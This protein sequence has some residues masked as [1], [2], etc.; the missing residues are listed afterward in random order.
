MVTVKNENMI[1]GAT[2]QD[3]ATPTFDS[4]FVTEQN[5]KQVFDINLLPSVILQ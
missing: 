1:V 4:S 2:V 3:F 5:S